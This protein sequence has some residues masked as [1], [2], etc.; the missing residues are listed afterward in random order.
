MSEN[1]PFSIADLLPIYAV[2]ER[3]SYLTLPLPDGR[4][5]DIVPR[6]FGQAQIAVSR[7]MEAMTYDD[8]W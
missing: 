7:D 4:V 5:A 8:M 1:E 2:N 3:G 6:T